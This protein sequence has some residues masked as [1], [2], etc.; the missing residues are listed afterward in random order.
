MSVLG[1]V[2]RKFNMSFTDIAKELGVASQTVNDWVKGKRKIPKKRLEQLVNLFDL[3]CEYFVKSEI[4]LNEVERL[5]IELKYYQSINKLKE[6]KQYRY[7]S[8][9]NEINNLS[10]KIEDKKLLLKIE[11]LF[12]GG[13]KLSDVNYNPHSVKNYLI[14]EELVNLLSRADENKEKINNLVIILL[15]KKQQRAF[16]IAERFRKE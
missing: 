9:Q 2:A 5:T 11:K 3:P 16:E 14:F 12:E 4:D 10:R 8:H 7:W 1:Y 13:G 6:D 15:G